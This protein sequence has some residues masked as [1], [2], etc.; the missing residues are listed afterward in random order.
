MSEVGIVH[1]SKKKYINFLKSAKEY[2]TEEHLAKIELDFQKA[3]N[4]NPEKKVK[5][6]KELKKQQEKR[7]LL[8]EQGIS[9]TISSGMNKVYEKKKLAKV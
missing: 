5:T 9:T 8:K 3:F 2:L 7:N 1:V 6:E 4:F